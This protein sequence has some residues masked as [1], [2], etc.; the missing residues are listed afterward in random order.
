MV[1][2]MAAGHDLLID[3]WPSVCA[4]V[5]GARLV[6]AGDGDDRARLHR[7]VEAEGLAAAVTFLGRV[8]DGALAALYSDA[9]VFVLPS[10]N[11]GFGYVFLEA[12]AS[13]CACIGARGA[14][15]EI[16]QDGETGLLVE[17]ADRPRL[18]AALIRL[19]GDRA[20]ARRM[21][22]AGRDRVRTAFAFPR[23]VSDL[24]DALALVAAC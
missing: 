21:G 16:I 23:L 10:V 1:G 7:R 24:R 19:L 20:E 18:A 17:A 11:E 6:I 5:P 13:G 2:R 15:A 14:A 12:M 4:A 3:V 22:A 9:G 8:D